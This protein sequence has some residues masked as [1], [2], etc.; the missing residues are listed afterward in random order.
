MD[1]KWYIITT[2]SGKEDK[3][4][5]ALKNRIISEKMDDDFEKFAVMNVPSI[6]AKELEKKHQ[7]LPYKIRSKNL[8]PGYIFVKMNMTN[9][10]W[11]MI[12]NTQDVTGLVGSSGERTKPTPVPKRE[13]RKMF[14][15]V[16]KHN[17]NFASGKITTP[18]IPG[19]VVE[20]IEGHAK[21]QIGKIIENDDATQISIVEIVMFERKTPIEVEHRKLRIKN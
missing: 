1:E 21:G 15:E 14:T 17:V 10:A 18:F 7:N 13:I 6:S 2:I 5:E 19:T 9:E 20:I 16:E 8:Y 12:R 11:Y 4:I 3:V